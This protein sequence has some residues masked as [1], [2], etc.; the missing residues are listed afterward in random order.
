MAMFNSYVWHNQ[1][2]TP[3]VTAPCNEKKLRA[4]SQ[5]E[6]DVN[7]AI[8]LSCHSVAQCQSGHG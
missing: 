2:V 7:Q 5:D 1:R 4:S 3:G 6:E 8:Q